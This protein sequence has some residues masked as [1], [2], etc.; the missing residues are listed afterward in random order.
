MSFFQQGKEIQNNVFPKIFVYY[1]RAWK[2]EWLPDHWSSGRG[3][4]H[5]IEAA[6]RLKIGIE[7]KKQDWNPGR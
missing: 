4:W 2:I 6:D 7:A 5:E 3:L 1:A